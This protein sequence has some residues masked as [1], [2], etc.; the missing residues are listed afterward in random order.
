MSGNVAHTVK[1]GSGTTSAFYD[2]EQTFS[3]ALSAGGS[4]TS[5]LIKME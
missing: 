5:T 1:A 3:G 2:D 4:D